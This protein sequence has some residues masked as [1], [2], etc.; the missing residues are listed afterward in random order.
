MLCGACITRA[1]EHS[2]GWF[3]GASRVSAGVCSCVAGGCCCAGGVCVT[4]L[5]MDTEDNE[6][7]LDARGVAY[8]PVDAVDTIVKIC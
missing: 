8:A 5:A 7:A 4:G 1:F 2:G 3:R 6:A